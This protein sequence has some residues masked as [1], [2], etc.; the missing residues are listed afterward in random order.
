MAMTERA[1]RT[2][3]LEQVRAAI[4]SRSRFAITSHVQP[5]GDAIGSSLAMA[6][7]LRALGTQVQV[8]FR[9][10]PPD[11]YRV[12]PGVSEITLGETIDPDWDAVIVM[13]CGSLERTGL[14]GLE[15]RFVVNIDHH[16]GNTMFGAVGWFDASAA[17]CG[18][19]VFDIIRA[20]GVPLSEPIATHLYLAVLTD[21]GAFHHANITSRTFEV[22][23]QAV[24]AGVNPARM[25][26][27]VFS[28]SSLGKLRLTG[29]L[30]TSMELAADDRLAILHM[31]DTLLAATGCDRRDTEGLINLPLMARAVRAVVM[32]KDGDDGQLRVS[33][34]SKEPIDVRAVAQ[35]YGGGGHTNAAGFTAA[36]TVEHLKPALI[37]SVHDAIERGSIP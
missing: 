13:E 7:A 21:T 31:D 23:R 28:S 4:A 34:R 32:F 22:A 27:Q 33:L 14:S 15:R 24:E 29:R 9:D 2:T 6:F 1:D 3:P 19:M 12:F 17:A 16:L 18:E 25:A 37:A 35:A 30:L 10:P 36:G 8:V 5:D 20:L 26:G 11:T